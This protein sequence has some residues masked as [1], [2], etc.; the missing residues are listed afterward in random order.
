MKYCII[1]ITL[2]LH[3]LPAAAAEPA[4]ALLAE[5]TRPNAP[6]MAEVDVPALIPMDEPGDVKDQPTGPVADLF[7]LEELKDT[8]SEAA[9]LDLPDVNLP[10][11]DIPLALNSKVE[12]FLYYFQTSGRQSFSRWLSRSSRY[13]PMMKAILKREGMP[14][15]LVY[16]AMIESG[17]QLHARSWANAVG[18]W[19]FISGTGR[20]YSLRIDQWVDE[21]KDPV[22][23]TTAAALYLKELYGMFKGDWYLATAGYNAGENKILRAINMY[24]TSDFWEISRGSYLKRETKEYVPKLLAAAII[25]KDPARYGFSDIAYLPAIEFETIKIPSRTDLELVAKLSGTTYETIRELNPDLRHWCTPP[26]YPGYELKLPKGTKQQF[27]LEY[28]K[29]PEDKRFTEKVLY[30]RYQARKKDSLKAIAHRFGTSP[31]V[32]SELNN[33][34]SKSRIAGKT[35]VVPVRQTMDFSHEGRTSHASAKKGNYFKFYTV[36]KGDTLNTLA[37]RFNVSTKLLSTWNHL[38]NKVALK[39]GRRIIIA[40]FVEKNGEMIPSGEKS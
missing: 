5:L 22:K 31:D 6:L 1:I 34:S 29:V 37:K 4:Q 11:S 38:K 10:L 39:P 16:V 21:R 15:D 13:I 25:A 18:P 9:E 17:F 8:S 20:R 19:Q 3:A 32:L 7:T 36:R 23:A 2:L 28:A 40:K 30:T 14:E 35:L 26:N 33:L 12:Y 27:E 24:N